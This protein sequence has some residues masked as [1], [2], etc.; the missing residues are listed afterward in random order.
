M[1]HQ[2]KYIIISLGLSLASPIFAQPGFDGNLYYRAYL[3]TPGGELPFQFS[4][5]VDQVEQKKISSGEIYNVTE[6]ISFQAR[7]LD[8]DSIEILLPVF[9]CKILAGSSD[10]KTFNGTWQ[11]YSRPGEYKLSFSAV[12]SPNRYPYRF[13]ENPLPP[14]SN[15][16]GRWDA[17]IT[18]ESTT[19]STVGIF[20]QTG[21]RLTGTFLTTTGDYRFLEGDVSADSFFLSAFDGSHAFLFKGKILDDGSLD[22]DFWSGKHYHA[23]FTA[24][25]NEN[26]KLPDAKKLTYLKE[27][28]SKIEFSFPDENGKI[29]S[30]NDEE[31]KNKP[32]VILIT[33][34]W[35]PNCMDEA[36]YMSEVEKKYKN[37][38]LRIIAL[39]FERQ[40]DSL[41]FRNNM[42][43]QRNHF[44]IH[45]P[46][47]NAGSN[48]K[49]SAALPMLNQVMGFPTTIILNRQHDIVE[50]HTG[51]SGPAT[52]EL[53]IQFQEQFEELLDSLPAK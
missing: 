6:R 36:S 1:R 21:N 27:G 33:G 44:G 19:D 13:K 18:D 42:I 23:T 8:N 46:M 10:Y 3:E 5:P 37:T 50:I 15:I 32:V 20:E 26:A 29:V 2:F 48:R 12:Y 16:S 35:C 14:K 52:G 4:I 49:A 11:D 40:T 17:L 39:Q 7:K 31:F 53:F 43:R 9:N 41:N 47:L 22:G 51:F 30:L 38:D 25:R 34:S 45:Y 28:Y 24:L